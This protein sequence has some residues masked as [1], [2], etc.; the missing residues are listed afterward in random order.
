MNDKFINAMI[1]Q[2]I[3]M[4]KRACKGEK[5]S[6]DEINF[7]LVTQQMSAKQ[8]SNNILPKLLGEAVSIFPKFIIGN[9]GQ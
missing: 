8:D 6:K 1:D 4:M 5:L 9:G 2:S 7:I 3:E